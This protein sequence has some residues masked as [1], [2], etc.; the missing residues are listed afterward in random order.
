MFALQYHYDYV[1][2]QLR[3]SIKWR[4]HDHPAIL[5]PFLGLLVARLP[6]RTLIY[7]RAAPSPRDPNMR[8]SVAQDDTGQE[9]S[10]VLNVDKFDRKEF[11][12]A[13]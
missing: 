5:A 2:L 11:L 3:I 8:R 4:A 10:R 9:V 13:N 12:I 1:L 7:W 6:K